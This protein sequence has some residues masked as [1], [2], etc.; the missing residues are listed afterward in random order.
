MNVNNGEVLGPRAARPSFDPNVFAKTIRK[1]D[2][3]RLYS[4]DN[5]EPILNRAIQAGYPTGSTFKLITAAAALEGGLITPDTVI[6][7]G[8]SIRVGGVTFKNAG[9]AVNGPVALRRALSV[10]SDVFFYRLGQEANG[11]G[12]GL[13][14]QNWARKLG[15]GRR[16]GIDLPGEAPGADPHAQVPQRRASPATGAAWPRRSRPRRRSRSASAASS[17][18]PG[19]WATTSTSRWARA[20]C[21]PTRSRWPWPTRRWPTAAGS[22]AR[23]WASGS[24][25][26]PAA[27]STRSERPRRAG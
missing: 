9:D 11:S 17:T 13:L 8:G 24:S 6:N 19:R 23:G 25:C 16:T 5:G 20:T 14:I 3:D 1:R 26:P 10:S 15:L 12:D 18:G 2:L 22:C 4:K 27:R 7:D 21:R